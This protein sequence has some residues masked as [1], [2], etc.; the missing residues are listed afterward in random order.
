MT[1]QNVKFFLGGIILSMILLF[2][3]QNWRVV[4]IRFLFWEFSMSLSLFVIF[5]F[6][7][8]LLVGW[9]ATF[10]MSKKKGKNVPE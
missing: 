2:F 7:S 5:L 6:L 1:K 9:L 10:L 8:G 3:F 4:E